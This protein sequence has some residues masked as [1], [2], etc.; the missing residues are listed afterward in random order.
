MPKSYIL[1]IKFETT[2]P[3][4]AAGGF[5]DVWRGSYDG[6]DLA[7]KTLRSCVQAEGTARRRRKVRYDIFSQTEHISDVPLLF[8]RRFC[9]EVVLW[10]SLNHPN[11]LGLVG[12][13]PW[14]DTP[15]AKLTMIS[16]WMPNGNIVEYIKHNE[17]HRLQLVCKRS[18]YRHIETDESP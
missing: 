6:R 16:E 15:E 12:V 14:D 11:I 17:S 18:S 5:A 8:Q 9:K 2:D 4:H 3:H 7:F 1:P 13:C 10:K